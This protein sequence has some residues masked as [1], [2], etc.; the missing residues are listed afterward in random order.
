MRF[1]LVRSSHS[2]GRNLWVFEWC[3]KYRYKMMRKWENMKLVEACIRQ[4]ACRHGI[5]IIALKAM[6]DHIHMVAWLPKG[7]DDETAAHLM[8]GASSRK[9]F[10]VKEKFTL[11]YPGHHFW[12][13]GYFAHTIGMT[14]LQTQIN[15]VEN[16]ELHH[17][18]F[19]PS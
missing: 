6:P 7:M 1:D 18:V 10:K 3:T 17:G 19:Y 9:L 4:A 13:R 8:K 11:R 5:K 15:Y 2:V 14:D 16:Q 12:S